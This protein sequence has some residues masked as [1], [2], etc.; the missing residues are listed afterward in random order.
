[1][2]TVT[3][4]LPYP[5]SFRAFRKF[6]RAGRHDLVQACILREVIDKRDDHV[7][8]EQKPLAGAAVRHIGKLVRADT[9]LLGK[10]LPVA[11]RL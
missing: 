5:C 10:D 3:D 2:G 4:N 11:L 9:K 1:M 8:K 6:F 7:A